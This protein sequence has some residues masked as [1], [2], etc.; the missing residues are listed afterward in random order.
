MRLK[1]PSLFLYFCCTGCT[2]VFF[3]PQQN[4]VRTPADMGLEYSNIYIDGPAGDIH[5]WFLS[6][7]GEGSSGTVLFAHGN[8][9]NMSTHIG[10]V[11]WLPEAGFNVVIF[12]YRGYGMSAGEPSPEGVVQDLQVMVQYLQ[13]LPEVRASG[14]VVYGHSLGGSA[15]I[16]AVAGLQNKTAICGLVTESAFSDYRRIARDKLSSFW[17]TFPLQW[18]PY[19]LIINSPNPLR[20]IARISGTPVLV[21]HGRNDEV[22]PFPHGEALYAAANEPKNSWWLQNKLH[23]QGMDNEQRQQFVKYMRAMFESGVCG[24]PKS[25]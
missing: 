14:M 7:K 23:N 9:E 3:Y 8:A 24:S 2:S 5:G 16:S 12:D 13:Q 17:F 22:I 19:I 21:I 4:L 11:S 18:L 10:G 15:A 6:A 1:W 25:T 20:D